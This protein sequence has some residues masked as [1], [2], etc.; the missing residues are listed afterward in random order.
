MERLQEHN[1]QSFMEDRL[2]KGAEK[3]YEIAFIVCTNDD[4]YMKECRAY[5]ERLIVPQGYT[6]S[7]I[8]ISGAD[9]MTAGYN[10]GMLSSNAKYKVYLHQDVFIVHPNFIADIIAYFNDNK[11]LGMLG[12][13]GTRIL[14]SDAQIWES[15]DVGGCYSVGTFSDCGYIAVKPEKEVAFEYVEY[16]DG[17]LMVTAYDINWDENIEGFH[18]YDASQ[19]LRF[20]KA[21]YKIAV[22]KQKDAWVFHDFGPL[23]LATYDLVRKR[24]CDLYSEFHYSDNMDTFALYDMC[25]KIAAS[26]KKMYNSNQLDAIRS[27][28]ADID[29]A[30]Y[31]SQDILDMYFLLEI[32]DLEKSNGVPESNRFMYSIKDYKMLQIKYLELRFLLIYSYFSKNGLKKLIEY[33]ESEKY[34]IVAVIVAGLH[35]IPYNDN[36]ILYGIGEMITAD[37][38]KKEWTQLIKEIQKYEDNNVPSSTGL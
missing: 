36:K 22:V 16:I 5:I 15:L 32:D 4:V 18:F 2:K 29:N 13:A 37:F 38:S 11:N 30:I 27:I 17:M 6:I 14:P 33:V 12:V 31:Y 34:S 3:E 21:G 35:T 28:L 10:E 20:Q 9:S 19:C 23:N 24:F 25:D 26:I 1:I 7:I 8:E